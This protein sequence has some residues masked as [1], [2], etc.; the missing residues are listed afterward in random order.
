MCG[1]CCHFEIP[2]TL[3]D[4]H[5]MAR[6][7]DMADKKVFEEYIQDKVSSQSS[8]FMIR[9][10]EERSCIFLT[11]EN[12]CAIHKAKPKACRFFTCTQNSSKHVLPWTATCTDPAQRADLWEQSVAA[13]MTRAYVKENGTTWNDADYYKAILGI[14]DNVVVSDRQKLKLARNKDGAPLAMIFDCSQC[15]KRGTCARETPITLDDIRRITKHLGLTWKAFF[16]DR[17]APEPSIHAGG[18]KLIRGEHC[19]FF[20]PEEHCTIKEVRP[21]HCRF[22]PCPRKTKTD[23]MMDCLFLGSGRVEEQFRHQVALAMTREYVAESGVTYNKHLVKKLLRTIDRLASDRSEVDKFCEKI[24][25]YRY[26]DDTLFI[27]KHKDKT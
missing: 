12:R 8:L 7:L 6:Y 25:P 22:T 14:Y 19:T 27:L 17:V 11:D 21:A 16:R 13:M 26:V 18:L 2:I 20:D 1:E 5:R 9:K 3:L 23:E 15:E 24:A 10:N 4:I